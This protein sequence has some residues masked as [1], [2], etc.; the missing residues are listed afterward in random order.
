MSTFVILNWV[1][2]AS[3]LKQNKQ[4]ENIILGTSF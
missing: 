4:L 1:T 2:F 3:G